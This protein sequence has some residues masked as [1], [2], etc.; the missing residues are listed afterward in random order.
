M[1]ELHSKTNDTQ[2]EKFYINNHAYV[3][4]LEEFKK[5]S[6]FK[7]GMNASLLAEDVHSQHWMRKRGMGAKNMALRDRREFLQAIF[8]A[9][10]ED[11]SGTMDED[12]LVKALL[13]LGLSQSITFAQRVMTIL[14]ENQKLE[15][16]RRNMSYD[17]RAP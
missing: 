3:F 5:A 16:D 1:K 4:R 14:K 13:S 2:L 15:R 7:L 6:I 17:Q 8:E 10:D 9:L 12:E 11:G